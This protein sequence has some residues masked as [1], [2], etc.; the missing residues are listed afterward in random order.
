MKF[1]NILGRE[2]EKSTRRMLDLALRLLRA[3]P[4]ITFA[5]TGPQRS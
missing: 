1:L 3:I 4:T 2:G 5:K